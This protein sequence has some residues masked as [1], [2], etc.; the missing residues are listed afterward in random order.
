MALKYR[1]ATPIS[2]RI[3]LSLLLLSVSSLWLDLNPALAVG[4][5]VSLPSLAAFSEL[6]QN[7]QKDV[8]RGVYVKNVLALPVL[9]GE[10]KTTAEAAMGPLKPGPEIYQ[11]I[12]VQPFVNARGTYTILTGSTL[13][14]EVRSAMAAASRHYVHLDELGRPPV[15]DGQRPELHR[16]APL[17]TAPI[18]IG[19]SMSFTTYLVMLSMRFASVPPT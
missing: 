15:G 9:L 13:L 17:V 16:D 6:V 4:S 5:A 10:L 14:P 8:V 11:S 2:L 19:L 3:C 7:G 12:G 1:K 18:L